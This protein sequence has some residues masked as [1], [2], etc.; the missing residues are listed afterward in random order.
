MKYIIIILAALS[1]SP[2][3][4]QKKGET[5]QKWKNQV[6]DNFDLYVRKVKFQREH[7]PWADVNFGLNNWLNADM[8]FPEGNAEAELF[9]SWAWKFGFGG[10]YRRDK[11]P[12][13]FQY[14]LQ[15]SVHRLGLSGSNALEKN[16]DGVTI[17]PLDLD[18]VRS[19]VV[20]SYMNVPLMIHL[21]FSNYGVDNGFTFGIGGEIGVRIN[22]YQRQIYDD[23]FGDRMTM[24][25]S[26]EYDFQRWRYG[27]AAQIGYG[28]YKLSAGYD[29]N[30][31]FRNGPD[32]RMVYLLL[33]IV[34]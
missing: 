31:V 4:A 8:A 28:N 6:Q 25:N 30:P 5:E 18:A 7:Q 26:G 17:S 23:A 21:D 3:T 13:V 16:D 32:L 9:R 29:L 20:V 2:L 11:T 12:L 1:F 10:K 15:F 14:G 34:L 24:K 19:Q 22:S 33:G 27:L